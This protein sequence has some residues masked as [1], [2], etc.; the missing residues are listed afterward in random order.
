M[1][2]IPRLTIKR[3]VSLAEEAGIPIGSIVDDVLTPR[4]RE[5]FAGIKDIKDITPLGEG[6]LSDFR[7]EVDR[8]CAEP[9][10]TLALVGVDI[11][12]YLIISGQN[13]MYRNY[14]DYLASGPGS[15]KTE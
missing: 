1:N 7:R 5:R 8:Y 9:S 3:Y 4:W 10:E 11:C 14:H 13:P 15:Q 12:A 2:R 6:M